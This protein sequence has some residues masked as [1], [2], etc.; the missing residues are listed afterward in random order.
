MLLVHF[1]D[2]Y[3][4]NKHTINDIKNTNF[5]KHI[6]AQIIFIFDDFSKFRNTFCALH[7]E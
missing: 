5:Y 3:L 6:S 2:L 4:D 1:L 7:F